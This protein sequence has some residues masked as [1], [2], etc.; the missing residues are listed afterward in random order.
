MLLLDGLGAVLG[1]IELLR[2]G[3][4]G[5]LIDSAR[6]EIARAVR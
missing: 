2:H 5:G 4:R 1:R 6:G 3:G